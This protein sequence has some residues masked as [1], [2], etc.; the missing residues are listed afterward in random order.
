MKKTILSVAVMIASFVGFN[1]LAQSPEE[2]VEVAETVETIS[3]DTPAKVEKVAKK[4]KF[5]RNKKDARQKRTA[6]VENRG[7]KRNIFEG[8]NLT[9]QQKAELKEICPKPKCEGEK[10]KCDSAATEC[11]A[12]PD[13]PKAKDRADRR[14]EPVNPEEAQAK[15]AEFL[16]KVKA[17]LTPEQYIQFLENNFS[18]GPRR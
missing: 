6:Q 1:A 5:D 2:V 7:P 3:A 13:C 17:I 16:S 8:L 15:K 12:R 11:T 18:F 14:P 9:D 4:G 10:A